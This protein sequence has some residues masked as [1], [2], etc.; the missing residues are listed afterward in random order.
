VTL[1]TSFLE[2]Y[3]L[4]I[5]ASA[6]RNITGASKFKVGYA[7]LTTPLLIGC[8]VILVLRIDVA[9]IHAYRI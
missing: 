7:I 8:F 9:Y 5:L 1:N 6:V 4:T 2:L 3:N